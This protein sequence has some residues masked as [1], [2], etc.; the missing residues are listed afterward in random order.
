[1][2]QYNAWVPAV[3]AAILLLSGCSN[4]PN[5][6]N[7]NLGRLGG[8]LAGAAIGN[9]MSDDDMAPVVGALIGSYIGGEAGRNKDKENQQNQ[10]KAAAAFNSTLAKA[11]A[12]WVDQKDQAQ[13]NMTVSQAYESNGRK[14]RPFTIK[15]T[16][17]G[18]AN[19]QNGVACLA[20]GAWEVA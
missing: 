7:E 18:A 15:R 9:Q 8:G 10:D 16:L 12:S 1:M 20:N 2:K 14:C 17:N 11:N 4:D 19:V 13:Y 3:V 6:S 5:V